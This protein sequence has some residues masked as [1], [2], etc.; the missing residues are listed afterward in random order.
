MYH[1]LSNRYHGFV[2]VLQLHPCTF[3]I[4]QKKR[5]YTTAVADRDSDYT[6]DMDACPPTEVLPWQVPSPMDLQRSKK[7]GRATDF[8]Y[9]VRPRSSGPV[10]VQ[11]R[12]KI[13]AVSAGYVS[14]LTTNQYIRQLTILQH[15][16]F[17]L[18]TLEAHWVQV[19]VE[20][21]AALRQGEINGPNPSRTKAARMRSYRQLDK[22]IEKREGDTTE[23]DNTVVMLLAVVTDDSAWILVDFARLARVHIVTRGTYW[24]ANDLAPDAQVS[25]VTGLSAPVS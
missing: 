21:Y 13:L 19:T 18:H 1:L 10:N 2:G 23:K 14:Q 5:P 15:A 6:D 22:F 25:S 9:L 24:T 3:T 4:G 20:D 12:G 16:A 7:R 11:A 17:V 8:A